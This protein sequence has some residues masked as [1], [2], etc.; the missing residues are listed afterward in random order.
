MRLNNKKGIYMKNII[1]SSVAAIA[2][3]TFAACAPKKP[4]D[5]KE[6]I[7]KAA[8]KTE[9]ASKATA[10]KS[11][12]PKTPLKVVAQPKAEAEA[13]AESKAEPVAVPAVDAKEAAVR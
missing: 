1:I 10:A 4:C 3:L 8:A 7:K 9:N 2:V 5:V 12:A 13:K 6:P 11:I